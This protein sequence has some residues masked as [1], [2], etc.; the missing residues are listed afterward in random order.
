MGKITILIGK[1]YH[2]NFV[3]KE[4]TDGSHKRIISSESVPTAKYP[5]ERKGLGVQ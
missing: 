3:A 1:Y 2:F 4:W 5:R